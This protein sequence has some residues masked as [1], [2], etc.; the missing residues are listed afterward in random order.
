M[1]T[2]TVTP[3][4]EL[5]NL[6][7]SHDTALAGAEHF[8]RKAEEQKRPLSSWER[9]MVDDKIKEATGI[10]TRIEAVK[11]KAA[12]STRD[13]AEARARLA[14]QG[15]GRFASAPPREEKRGGE[16]LMPE[17][18][19]RDYYESF[20]AKLGSGGALNA[21]MYEGSAPGGG[22][23]VPIE[24]S[25]LIVPLAPQDSAVRRLAKVIAT[26]SDL[27]VAQAITRAAFAPKAETSAFSTAQPSLSQFVLSAFPVGVETPMSIELSQDAPY[28]RTFVLDDMVTALLEYEEPLFISGSGSG[29]PQGMLGNVGAGIVAEPD[30][31]GNLVSIQATLN[32]LNTLKATYHTNASWLMQRATSLIIRAAQAGS[33]LFEPVFRREN[34][35]ELLHGY[36]CEYSSA[37]PAAAR[38]N[39]PVLFGDFRKGFLIGDR[40]GS[41][42]IMKV[43]EQDVTLAQQGVLTLLGYR[44]TDGRVMRSEALQGITIAAS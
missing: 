26:R 30:A 19:S 29:Q 24:V 42:M 8:V 2:I 22:F 10:K 27:K 5:K 20:Y 16:A 15:G 14:K 43:I 13:P 9:Q 39:T 38:G 4:D 25:G 40:G 1:S 41:A 7:Q 34:G 6:Q 44:R 21:A 35:V 36:P 31:Q 3:S 23:A 12:P 28:F 18:F 32:I 33:N 37:M 17:R 11:A